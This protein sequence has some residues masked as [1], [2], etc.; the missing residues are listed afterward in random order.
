MFKRLRLVLAGQFMLLSL[1][2]YVVLAFSSLALF[3]HGL[4]EIMD[5]RLREL[6]DVARGA[7]AVNGDHLHLRG[8]QS[9]VSMV[10]KRISIQ[11]WHRD[12]TLASAYG[13]PGV[14]TFIEGES[15]LVS[16]GERF[17]TMSS[18]IV[19]DGETVGYL[20][21]QVDTSLRDQVVQ[22]LFDAAVLLGPVLI[23]ALGLS[24]YWFA[25]IAIKPVRKTYDLQKRFLSDAGHELKT[26]VAVIQASLEILEQDLEE[27]PQSLDRLKRVQRSAERMRNLVADLLLLTKTEQGSAPLEMKTLSLDML[28]REVLG[29]FADLYEDKGV[30]LKAESIEAVQLEGNQQSL[31]IIFSN[32]LKNALMYTES[33][34]S[35]TVGLTRSGNHAVVTVADTGIGITPA[36]LERLFDRFFRVDESRSRE[37]GGSGLGLAIVKAMVDNHRGSIQVQSEPG[38]GTTFSITFPV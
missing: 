11:L 2:V 25:G 7:V 23:L 9:A 38:K 14:E 16:G 37:D 34:G 19:L 15:E 17:R 24:G 28:I 29:E 18:P 20:Q 26:P 31:E 3:R 8:D 10:H 6:A 35:V 22:E 33:G 5:E 36:D 27:Q 21:V 4:T 1:S 13:A 30:E 32:L 12:R